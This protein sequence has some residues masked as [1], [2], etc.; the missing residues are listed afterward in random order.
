MGF[1]SRRP[2]SKSVAVSRAARTAPPPCPEQLARV[3]PGGDADAEQGPRP[4]RPSRL[5]FRCGV[6]DVEDLGAPGHYRRDRGHAERARESR[7]AQRGGG[8][9]MQPRSRRRAAR[10]KHEA[11][12]R[13]EG[14]LDEESR[15]AAAQ[16]R[17]RRRRCCPRAPRSARRLR[18]LQRR[19]SPSRTC[20]GR[21]EVERGALDASTIL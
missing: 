6:D 17:R 15:L 14:G 3:K 16:G 10:R 4:R 11:S 19:R 5:L 12:A 13:R 18:T 8:P 1:T 9:R 21:D 7:R 2:R 20:R